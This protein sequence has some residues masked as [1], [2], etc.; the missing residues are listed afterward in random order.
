MDHKKKEMLKRAWEMLDPRA[1]YALLNASLKERVSALARGNPARIKEILA[2]IE[3]Y[4]V[5]DEN[6]INHL[7]RS[8]NYSTGNAENNLD[9][10]AKTSQSASE[11][12]EGVKIPDHTIIE[13]LGQGAMGAVYR[14]K[15][16][17]LNRSVAIKT[18]I[19][20]CI[21]NLLLFSREAKAMAKLE[22]PHITPIYHMGMGI[23]EQGNR[24]PY[25][26][27]KLVDGCD[28]ETLLH[29]EDTRFDTEQKIRILSQ[30]SEAIA[31]GHDQ[32]IVHRDLKPANIM[33]DKDMNAY[34]ADFGLAKILELA[35]SIEGK[36]SSPLS[37][38]GEIKG[39][40]I[41]MAPEQILGETS[42]AVD[43]FALGAIIYETMTGKKY[44]EGNWRGIYSLIDA[45]NSGKAVPDEECYKN[46]PAEITSIIRKATA[47][48][49]ERRPSAK[50]IAQSL[51]A[52]LAKQ[53]VPLHDYT[54][55]EKLAK[56]VRKHASKL[57]LAASI[58]MAGTLAL[59]GYVDANSKAI[60][61][62][63]QAERTKELAE[64]EK[65]SLQ[66]RILQS[67][68]KA[69]RARL[70]ERLSSIERELLKKNYDTASEQLKLAK[71]YYP[72][73][74][75]SELNSIIKK[76]EK[77]H[78]WRWEIAQDE[79]RQLFDLEKKVRGITR[80][81]IDLPEDTK[82]DYKISRI[83]GKK[84]TPI[85]KGDEER[86]FELPADDYFIQAQPRG[87]HISGRTFSTY[88]NTVHLERGNPET[89]KVIKAP[90]ILGFV[91][92]TPG[93]ARKGTEV[94][95]LRVVQ[96]KPYYIQ[97]YH[98]NLREYT[99]FVRS[100]PDI[101]IRKKLWPTIM[102]ESGR[103]IPFRTKELLSQGFT[104]LHPAIGLTREQAQAY[105]NWYSKNKLPGARLASEEEIRRAMG[106]GLG[107][108]FPDGD[109]FRPEFSNAMPYCLRKE[110]SIARIIR[111]EQGRG[112]NRRQSIFD[113]VLG[114]IADACIGED[115]YT[116]IVGSS[117]RD[118]NMKSHNM[119]PLLVRTVPEID[120]VKHYM[121]QSA[122]WRLAKPYK[123]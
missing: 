120:A 35:N 77:N 116:Q 123:P 98:I 85:Y 82:V 9:S 22:H 93:P 58:G 1:Q 69:A 49:P 94:E 91:F 92:V 46:I 14:A 70:E 54:F 32:G 63:A 47:H 13:K 4:Q 43:V 105:A 101:E 107:R 72:S 81:E 96:L 6:S 20:P 57:A 39:T 53:D 17:A 111:A 3:P 115:G 19:L 23:D 106:E 118:L 51:N 66:A 60:K 11:E 102:D 44:R 68:K 42:P 40:P 65:L 75:L 76:S 10:F 16:D 18:V 50:E 61:A 52:H 34:V 7:L 26:T 15:H 5:L 74:T 71:E 121:L 113:M 56:K 59:A 89:I 38:P 2:G 84:F 62:K 108:A 87:L 55:K 104:E 97:A 31:Y 114:D 37:Q 12:A 73:E 95:G 45:I 122:G 117:F 112:E 41:Y 78:T 27:M 8:H 99:E 48:N 30:V 21:E 64:K 33:I 80:L 36:T 79:V 119:N 28:L 24:I 88:R 67:E 25:Y 109:E 86:Y 83:E 110:K 100:I 90:S 29:K 103:R